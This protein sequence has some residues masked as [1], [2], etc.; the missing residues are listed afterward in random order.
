[1]KTGK[2]ILAFAYLRL[3]REEMQGGESGSIT[4]QRMIITN[5]CRQ[6]GITLVRE[7]SDDGWSGGNFERP[8][9][10]EMMRQLETGQANTV[11]TKDL[12][13]L[14]R[15]MRESSYLAE[16][17]FPENGIRYI[18][19][20]DNFDTDHDNIMAPF[21][22][23]MNEVYLRDG[24]R[25]VKD[26]LKNKRENGLYCACPP[27]GYK[28]D[29]RNNNQLVPDEMTA[30]VVQ[31]IFARAADGDSSRQIALDLNADGIIPPLK[32]RVLY[33][34]AFSEEGAARVSDT[35]NYTTVKRILKNR[36]YLGHTVLGRSRK[37]SVKS[38]KKVSIPREDWAVTEDTH[39]PLVTATMFERAQENMGRGTKNYRQYEHVRKSIFSGIAVCEKC[40]YSLCS[41]G[42]VYKGEREKYWYL[43]CTHQRQDIAEPCEG[44]RIRYADLLEIVRRDLNALLSLSDDDINEM[45]QSL[46]DREASTD[47]LQ[48]KKLQIEKAQVRLS[49]IDK[50]ITKLYTD[51]AEGR[52]D[53]SRLNSMVAELEREAAGLNTM[54]EELATAGQAERIE[55]NYARFFR[56]AKEYTKIEAL[57]RDTLLTFVEK[58]EIGPKVLPEGIKVASRRNTPYRQSVRIFY[59]FIGELEGEPIRTMSQAVN[60]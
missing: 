20:S 54:I 31:R 34:D 10:Q 15:D 26:V 1:M 49:T 59:K 58:I 16:Q 32:Y 35:W 9:F 27:Y 37:V 48:T 28:K 11:I 22:F 21:Q 39:E 18:A 19:I 40:G 57:D 50:I 30:P 43:S 56:L 42:T 47:N 52:L 25:K 44:V 51:N 4:N 14:G 24:S 46:V 55:S 36:V 2:I 23:A 13:R 7:F 3:S 53:D 38:K 60:N 33:R 41:C 12:S 5:Y 29:S 45:V 6:N 17:F 8:A